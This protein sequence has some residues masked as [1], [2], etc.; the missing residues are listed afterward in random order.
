MDQHELLIRHAVA[1]A[2]KRKQPLDRE[3]LETVLNLR[4]FHDATAPQEWPAGS[5][6]HLMLVR[7]PSHGPSGVPDVDRL[8]E[9]L[10]SF[11]R[12]LRGTGRMASSSADPRELA[13]EAR[14][15]A[16]RMPDACADPTRHGAAK[17]LVEFG[18]SIGLSLDG[19]GSME[20]LNQRMQQIM[21]AWNALPDDQRMAMSPSSAHQ[22]SLRGMAATDLMASL[23]A[24]DDDVDDVFGLGDED[25]N[26]PFADVPEV[27]ADV[28]A[29]PFVQQCRRLVE[30]V[31]ERG[32]EITPK[33]VLRLAP[34]REAYDRLG[35]GEWEREGA[36][37]AY[38]DL[39]AELP[40]EAQERWTAT[41]TT[42]ESFRSAA[43]CRPLDR[44]WTAC[45]EAGVIELSRTRAYAAW[46]EPSS[47]EEWRH[48]GVV[49]A[50][51]VMI[52]AA[53]VRL[54][55]LM[56]ALLHLLDPQRRS[57]PLAELEE[58]WWDSPKNYLTELG[59]RDERARLHSDSALHR[60]LHEMDDLG[61]WRRDGEALLPTALGHD[62]ALMA[63]TLVEEGVIDY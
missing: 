22:G 44:L 15:A 30:W 11:W 1:W 61:V 29:A 56:G 58:W 40:P 12:F 35:L 34:A 43:D 7:W 25:G 57:L 18:E 2:D 47:D 5:A 36:R 13:K 19:A 16:P 26:I 48:L 37:L 27:A 10:D 59:Y 38:G 20:E 63:S 54:P 31:G 33:Q 50:S 17:S 39:V 6:E 53:P 9:T 55:P 23:L 62:V 28:R 21:E 32:R 14:R 45:L 60:A 8:A 46:D 41:A 52:H 3:L 24:G 42:R 51:A 49:L 4:D